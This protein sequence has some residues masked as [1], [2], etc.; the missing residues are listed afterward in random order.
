[1]A[2]RRARLERETAE[3]KVIL[4]LA[5]EGTGQAQ[6]DTG[7]GMLDHLLTLLAWHGLFDITIEAKGDLKV[8]PHHTVEDVALALGKALREA[9][10]D[11]RGIQRM[12]HAIIPM[13]EAL[14]MVAVD[15]G[16]RGYAAVEA[17]FSTERIGELPTELIH[18]FLASMALE[19]QMNLHARVLH[20][21]NDHHKAEA[22]FKAL[23]RALDAA[24]RLDE[25]IPERPPSTKE[26]IEG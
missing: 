6:V 16:G 12:G 8:D 5:L 1:M 23:A 25:R 4:E 10:G 9:L 7:L 22:L 3:T 26:V 21:L 2:E 15:L 24:T 19:A 17:S 14:A 11:R 13:D 20:G 18:H